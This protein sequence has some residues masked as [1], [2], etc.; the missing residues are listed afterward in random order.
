MMNIIQDVHLC[1]GNILNNRE[2]LS[3]HH[4]IYPLFLEFLPFQ[5]DIHKPL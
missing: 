1:K 4:V 3:P 5:K 2:H